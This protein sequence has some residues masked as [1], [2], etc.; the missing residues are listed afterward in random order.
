[1]VLIK[2]P[3]D[4]LAK[5]KTFGDQVL[6][7]KQNYKSSRYLNA[8]SHEHSKWG[9]WLFAEKFGLVDAIN[10]D[11]QAEGDSYDF[12]INGK[13]I[14]IKA[15]SYWRFPEL[16]V[17]PNEKKADFYVLVGI[18][19]EEKRGRLAGFASY[20]QLFDEANYVN[21][22]GL[23]WRYM[24]AERDLCKDWRVISGKE[25]CS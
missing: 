9:E 19:K 15:S 16:K 4:I 21:Y 20:A 8:D 18:S 7:L 23:G 13:T 2:I 11:V 5:S 3:D 1:M 12:L 14:D 10:W 25:S 6:A 22:R 24:L 17:F